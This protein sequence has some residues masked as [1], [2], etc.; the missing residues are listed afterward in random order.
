MP[1]EVGFTFNFKT[2][3]LGLDDAKV[4]DLYESFEKFR[5]NNIEVFQPKQ[6]KQAFKNYGFDKTKPEMYSMITWIT[7]ANEFSGT[8]GMTFDEFVQYAA[9][10]FS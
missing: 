3:G 7:D 10:F 9:Y 2:A 8:A 5:S 1:N 6:M 4:A